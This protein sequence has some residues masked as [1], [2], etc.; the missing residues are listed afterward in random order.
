MNEQQKLRCFVATAG[1]WPNDLDE[2]G[3]S[4]AALE[5]KLLTQRAHVCTNL[6]VGSRR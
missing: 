4:R 2:D 1:Y 6:I 5:T 3:G